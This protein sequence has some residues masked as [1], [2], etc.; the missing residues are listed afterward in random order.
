MNWPAYPEYKETAVEW[1][2]KI[3]IGWTS[4]TLRH[5]L[6]Q[7]V[8]DGPHETPE[9]VDTGIPFLSVDGIQDGE[10]VF[11]GCRYISESDHA[12]F[13]K[14]A[15]PQRGDV[16][17]GK[18]ASTGKIAQVKT[19]QEFN[20][21]SP[22][23]IL[24]PRVGLCTSAFMEYFLKSLGS[25]YEIDGLCTNNTQKNISMEDIPRLNF[26]LPPVRE[27][28]VIADFLDRETDRIDSLIV[29]QNQLIATLHEDRT[30][31]ITHAVTKGLNP[32]ADMKDS[33]LD[34]LG[35]IP[36]NWRAAPLKHVLRAETGAI[37]AGPFGSDL[38]ASE[39]TGNYAKVF[40]QRAVLDRDPL[41]GPEWVSESKYQAM[42]VFEVVPGDVLVTTRGS[43]GRAFEVPVTAPRGVLHP[44]VIRIRVDQSLLVN[45][46]LLLL[47]NESPSLRQQFT[48]LSNA[49]TIEVIY[50]ATLASCIVPIPPLAEQKEIV[51]YL[52][53]RC[54]KMDLLIAK[55]TEMVAVL[56]EY[57]AALITAAVTGRIDVREAE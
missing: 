32:D 42:R 35:E 44:C 57:R 47:L 56:R 13:S 11:E 49:T 31:T 12:R 16:L 25:Q 51:D 36:A 29:K 55:A 19:S 15:R 45:D 50:S 14:K 33:R 54:G 48:F 22:L 52:Q 18:A 10:L 1:L 21:W 24:R 5:L 8:S 6:A 41:A 40:N 17:M 26:A 4:L 28:E 2:G 7:P 39:M 34:S 53:L 20:V 23:A 9:F 38:T 27:Q 43:I 46:F 30:A 37:K 3:P